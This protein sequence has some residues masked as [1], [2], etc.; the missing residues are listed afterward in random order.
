MTRP[1][2]VLASI[3]MA[4]PLMGP[5][6][7][8]A[9]DSPY[10]KA[11]WDVEGTPPPGHMRVAGYLYNSNIRDA[12]NVW[13][14]VDE[15]KDD[16]TVTAAHQRRLFGDVRSRGRMAFDV[17]VSGAAASYR[18]VVESVDWLLECR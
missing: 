1:R 17:P 6:V 15:L 14:R 12:A 13:L 16:G 10:L 4:L 7:A 2:R 8:L 3:F 18:V 9:A 5:V 11:E